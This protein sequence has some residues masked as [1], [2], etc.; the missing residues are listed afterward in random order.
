[1][2]VAYLSDIFTSLNELNLHMQGR[3]TTIFQ[4]ND[5]IEAM[6][7]KLDL[8]IIRLKKRIFDS[9]PTLYEF[10]QFKQENISD[11]IIKVFCEHLEML[12]ETFDYYFPKNKINIE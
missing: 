5:K 6:K 8:W 1:M 7:K 4:V 9:F 10:L 3:N 12:K 11:N 2:K